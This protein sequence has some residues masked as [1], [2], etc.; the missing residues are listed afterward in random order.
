MQQHGEPDADAHAVHRG[1]QGLGERLQHRHQSLVAGLLVLEHGRDR[2][3]R[4]G[5]GRRRRRGRSP[6]TTTQRRRSS[7]GRLLQRRGHGVPEL[8]VEGVER[9]G[10]VEGEGAHAVT[11]VDEQDVGHCGP[12]R[13][14]GGRTVDDGATRARSPRPGLPAA[15]VAANLMGSR[16][17]GRRRD[18]HPEPEPIPM[19]PTNAEATAADRAHVFH[20][21]SAQ[22][23]IS[24]L[25]IAGGE[26]ATFWDNEGNQLPRLLVAAG[27]PQPR[28]PAP[29]DDR[30]HQGPGRPAVHGRPVFANDARTEAARL[31]ASHAP[32]GLDTVFFTNGGAEANENA[33]RL[34]RLHTGRHK[35]LSTYRSYHG[36]TAGAIALTG[37]PRRWAS[38]P[39]ISGRRALLRPLPATA[40]RSTPPPMPRSASAPS[41]T[42]SRSSPWRARPRSP[43]I[44]LETIVGTNGVLIPPDG[45]LAG[46]RE[47]CDRHGI[48]MISDEVMVGFGRV[49]EWFA[50][51]HWGIE[52]RP[53]H[54]RQGRELR[55]RAARRRADLRA[56]S[57]PPSTS[58]RSPV[59]SPTAATH[60]RAPPRWSRSTSSPTT[61]SPSGP[62]RLGEEV[63][64]PAL[65][66]MAARHPSRRRRARPRLLLRHRAGAR[67]APPASRS[68]PSTP[69]EPTPRR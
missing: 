23:L 33:I 57:P 45:Y 54:L 7:V 48:M 27:Q 21:W 43:A 24:P 26:G 65:E 18:F 4:R 16:A 1:D 20:S 50:V 13:S 40:R 41:P 39:A 8:L 31:I 10:P 56:R 3:S 15:P 19:S 5:P 51:D 9:I 63:I 37:D 17:P 35:V 69:Q 61:A 66:A 25:P 36:A 55:L 12:P 46:V 53:D 47:L 29:P 34:A 14:V 59:A 44:M 64:R 52:P 67:P 28:P 68:F 11:V 62:A 30:G 22:A 38:E 42:S 49:G 58:G 2:P 60:W 32:G 6:V